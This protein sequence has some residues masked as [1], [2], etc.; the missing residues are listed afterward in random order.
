MTSLPIIQPD[1]SGDV[2]RCNRAYPYYVPTPIV[3]DRCSHPTVSWECTRDVEEPCV[4]RLLRAYAE[5]RDY[6][7]I[8]EMGGTIHPPSVS[9]VAHVG[10]SV[11]FPRALTDYEQKTVYRIMR[12]WCDEADREPRR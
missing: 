8:L 6:R 5:L 2:P 7:T 9:A 3:D 11:T 12:S 4:P 10:V 1:E